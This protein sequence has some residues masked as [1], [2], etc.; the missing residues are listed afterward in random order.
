MLTL[1]FLGVGSAFAK[2]N[3][4]SNA[5]IEAWSS[6]PDNQPEPDD[7]LLL[8][9]GTTGPIALH[10]LKSE[11]GYGYLDASGRP[12]FAAIRRVFI[13]HLHSDHVGGLEEL[14]MRTRFSVPHA[15]EKPFRPQLIGTP[16]LLQ[17]LWEQTLRGGLGVLE[18]RSAGLE[19]Y[20]HVQ[21]LHPPG[22]GSPDCFMMLERYEFAV[23]PT[24]HIQ[25]HHPHDWPSYGL[26][27]RDVP[28]GEMVLY[29][30]DTRFD[31]GNLG[32]RM[33][34][35]RLIFHEVQLDP[36]AGATH[37]SLPPAQR[38]PVVHSL[39]SELRTMPAEIRCKTLLYHYDDEWDDPCYDFVATE[40]AGFARPRH[41]YVLFSHT[42]R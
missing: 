10:H 20:F 5:L 17:R 33:S 42:A 32:G 41:R 9:F 35:A 14:A 12:G 37:A 4:Q 31:F 21:P 29:T 27:M 25:M 22:G 8:D 1:T 24:H 38:P 19:D 28:T 26:V 34:R 15:G 11:P 3:F 7:T 18:G 2:R 39:L 30:G 16:E 6:D 36:P 40:F 23:F 13:S